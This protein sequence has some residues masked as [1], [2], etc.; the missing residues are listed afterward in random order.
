MCGCS[1][2]GIR[3]KR[4]SAMC[5]AKMAAV[6]ASLNVRH[7]TSDVQPLDQGFRQGGGAHARLHGGNIIRHTPKFHDVMFEI[8][9]GKT[10]ARITVAG[11]PNGSGIQQIA[12][13]G[14]GAQRRKRLRGARADVQDL[15]VVVEILVSKTAL[16]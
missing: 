7:S 8:G 6:G 10:G 9:D 11:L 3:V 12:S 13:L 16:M 2:M 4:A 15:E 5:Y 14:L 1:C